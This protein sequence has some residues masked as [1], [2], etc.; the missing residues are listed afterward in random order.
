MGYLYKTCSERTVFIKTIVKQLIEIWECEWDR[1]GKF[2]I[3]KFRI[4]RILF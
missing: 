2:R 4:E 3:G 1:N